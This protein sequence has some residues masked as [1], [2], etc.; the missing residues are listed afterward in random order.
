AILRSTSFR[1][2]LTRSLSVNIGRIISMIIFCSSGSFR[3]G[4]CLQYFFPYSRRLMQRQMC[5]FAPSRLTHW[6]RRYIQPHSP[7]TRRSE[8][9]N[10]LVYLP[11]SVLL[12]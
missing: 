9:A 11:C 3:L 8:S 4:E 5:S 7:Q 2:A 10:L 1:A 12:L 6:V